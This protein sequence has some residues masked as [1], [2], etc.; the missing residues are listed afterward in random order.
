MR[1]RVLIERAKWMR[2]NPTPAELRLWHALRAGRFESHKFRRQVV[3]GRYIADFACRM[4]SML[5]IEVDGDAHDFQGQYDERRTSFLNQLGYRIIRFHND[6]VMKHLEGVLI[7]LGEFVA[8]PS[9]G[10]ASRAH[11]LPFGGEGYSLTARSS[12]PCR[13]P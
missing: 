8:A 12:P 1:D 4:P 5:I 2:A 3:I 11:P 7:A 13:R 6:D 9:P 10:L